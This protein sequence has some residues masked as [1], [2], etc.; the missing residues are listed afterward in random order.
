MPPGLAGEALAEILE[1]VE[2]RRFSTNKIFGSQ[3]KRKRGVL[4]RIGKGDAKNMDWDWRP[5][6]YG[7]SY[8]SD[9]FEKRVRPWLNAKDADQAKVHRTLWV[10]LEHRAVAAAVAEVRHML[11][12]A[13]ANKTITSVLKMN[14][15]A[16]SIRWYRICRA[17]RSLRALTVNMSP[18][19]KHC[20]G[21]L[22]RYRNSSQLQQKTN[23]G[24]NRMW[25]GCKKEKKL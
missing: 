9:D 21:R 25:F 15:N 5:F 3:R 12:N 11:S 8:G 7:Y 16:K 24:F 10:S 17:K 19:R 18:G 14:T 1:S 23:R 4:V 2:L 13:N 20:R 6:Y 22:P